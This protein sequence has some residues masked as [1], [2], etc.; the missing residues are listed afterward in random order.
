M[1]KTMMKTTLAIIALCAFLS[2]PLP[3]QKFIAENGQFKLNGKPFRILSGEMHYARIPEAYWKDRMLK[4][5]SMGLNAICTYVFWNAHEPSPGTFDFTGNLDIAR[6]IR[7][8]QEVGLYVLLRPGPYVCSEWDFGGLP[9]WLLK[10][11]ELKIR[12]LYPTYW[13]AA[14]KYLTRLGKEL[15]G[16]TI[17]Q[18]G[19]IIAVQVENEYGSYGDDKQYL[20]EL[21]KTLR[22]VGFDCLLYTSDGGSQML[23]EAGTLDNAVPAV[24]FASD[25]QG[26]FKAL[27]A[28]RKNIPEMNGEFWT[29]WFTQWGN[30]RWGSQDLERQK[31]DIQWML[32]TGKSMNFYMFHGGTNFGFMAGANKGREFST[33]VT[34]YDYG[35]PLTEDGR[36]A[37]SYFAYREIL[38]RFQPAGTV[39][40]DLPPPIRS[41]DIPEIQFTQSA[42]LFENLPKPIAS[43]Q[44]RPMEAYGQDYGY[45]LYRTKL[46]PAQH[47]KLRITEVHDYAQIYVDGDLVGTM[48]RRMGDVD[49]LTLPKPTGKER[50]L[51]ILVEAL[52][53]VNF[54]DEMIDR[55]GITERVTIGGQ[56]LMNWQVYLLPMTNV[57]RLNYKA[58]PVTSAPSLFRGTFA[59]DTVGD[60]F[61]DLRGWN[62][63]VVWVNGHNLGRFWISAGPQRDL[64]LPGPWLKRGAN[65]IIVFDL[66]ASKPAVLKGDAQRTSN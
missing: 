23:L 17:D 65:E 2:I 3:A 45:I 26:E 53:R 30:E 56:T 12:C 46:L 49:T 18:G 52:G 32:E 63:G 47:G 36:P 58:L 1:A 10:D 44:P 8:A 9:A 38:R 55:K 27:E 4:A 34:S 24:N 6:F 16:L 5:K 66:D 33:D 48:D 13:N 61:L 50:T 35:A 64:Y 31:K 51:D 11:P 14:K 62:K 29:G 20:R 39:L 25:P 42:A 21:E 60:T 54:G 37:P 41:I 57:S 22:S 15:K 59:L 7:T 19:P 40:P 43:V 28:F